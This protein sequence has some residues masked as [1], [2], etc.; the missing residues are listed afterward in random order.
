MGPDP[1]VVALKHTSP[2]IY[3]E[4]YVVATMMIAR[5]RGTWNVAP[6]GIFYLDRHFQPSSMNCNQHLGDIQILS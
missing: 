3:V 1:M 6:C 2:N 4:L 5:P